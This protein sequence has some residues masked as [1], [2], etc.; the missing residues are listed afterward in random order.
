VTPS[1]RLY[2]LTVVGCALEW[3]AAGLLGADA[4]RALGTPAGPGAPTLAAAGALVVLG[5]ASVAALL[6][7]PAPRAGRAPAA[8]AS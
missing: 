2:Q 3:F 8:P 1:R 7:T 5:L 4:L 6:R